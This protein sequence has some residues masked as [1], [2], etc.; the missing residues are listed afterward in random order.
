MTV[1]D[2]MLLIDAVA[3]FSTQEEWDNSGLLV[4]SPS[5]EISAVLF[6]LDVT[7]AVIDEAL[8]CGA[9]LIVTHHP[10]MFSPRH[11]LTDEDYEGRLLQRLIRMN[12]SLIAAHTCLDKAPGGVNDALAAVCRLTNIQGEGYVRVGALP[13]PLEAGALSLRLSEALGDTVRCMGPKDAV[14]RTLGLCSGGGSG[15]WEQAAA[16]GC[17][18]FLSGE[19]KHHHALAMADAGI[20]ALECGHFATELPGILT[21]A[22][23][24]QNALDTVE[25]KVRIFQS[26]SEAYGFPR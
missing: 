11:R 1:H 13:E 18:A 26:A 17:D 4:G 19:I 2:L 9:E 10:L 12:L 7:D 24:L 25:Y 16:L 20:V 6:A 3:P 14:I 5:Q 21:L 8:A 23:A 22:E 15:E